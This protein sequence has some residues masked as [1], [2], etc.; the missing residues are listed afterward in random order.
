MEI[1]LSSDGMCVRRDKKLTTAGLAISIYK[2]SLML[3][4]LSP[5]RRGAKSD[6]RA[7]PLVL[8]INANVACD[9]CSAVNTKSKALQNENLHHELF[10]SP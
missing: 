5:R 1:L 9:H 6:R 7:M 3:D 2:H 10:K 4:L 8:L